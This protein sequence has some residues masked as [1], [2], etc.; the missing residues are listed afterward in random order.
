MTFSCVTIE[1]VSESTCGCSTARS[2]TVRSRFDL[3]RA[4]YQDIG[5]EGSCHKVQD[6]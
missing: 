1:D 5:L 3:S 4:S 6:C 2:D